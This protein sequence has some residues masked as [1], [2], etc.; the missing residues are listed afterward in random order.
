METCK[1]ITFCKGLERSEKK[2]SSFTEWKNLE[3]KMTLEQRQK[4]LDFLYPRGFKTWIQIAQITDKDLRNETLKIGC[5]R[6]DDDDDDKQDLKLDDSTMILIEQPRLTYCCLA[7]LYEFNCL[8]CREHH[9]PI[10]VSV[11][12]ALE[13]AREILKLPPPYSSS[14]VDAPL[15]HCEEKKS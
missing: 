7:C 15:P 2:N 1:F 10:D 11:H 13:K 8:V 6:N 12:D 14:S 3:M 4:W 9:L 5:I